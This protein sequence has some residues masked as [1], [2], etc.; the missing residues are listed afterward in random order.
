MWIYTYIE[1]FKYYVAYIFTWW[2]KMI[3]TKVYARNQTT[4]PSEYRKKY[5]VQPNDIV[6]WEENENGE[7]TITFRKKITF[8]EMLGKG[9]IKETT[10]AVELEKE[11]YEWDYY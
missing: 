9:T 3:R 5:N 11:L 6:E 2:L 1:I 7:L 8:R 4:I 10:N